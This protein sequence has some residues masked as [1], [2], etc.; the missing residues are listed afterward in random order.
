MK[1]Y[2]ANNSTLVIWGV[3][4]EN[5]SEAGYSIEYVNQWAT[6]RSGLN[7]SGIKNKAQTKPVRLTVNLM[8]DSAEKHALLAAHKSDND[9]GVSAHTQ[10]GTLEKIL[11]IDGVLE[12]IGSRTRGVQT[13]DETTDDVLTFFFLD[14]EEA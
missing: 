6:A 11:L 3:P 9:N 1:N 4:I 7:R 2:S 10:I 14:S 13:A 12:N 8:P 5:L